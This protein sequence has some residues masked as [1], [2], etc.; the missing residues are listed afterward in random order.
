MTYKKVYH[1]NVLDEI[2]NGKEVCCLDRKERDVFAVNNLAVK[3]VVRLIND[4]KEDNDRY[5]FWR[6]E[7]KDA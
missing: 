6:E 4:A 1:F 7:L 3:Y 2:E 5:E